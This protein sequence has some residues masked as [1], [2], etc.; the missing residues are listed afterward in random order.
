[1][2][3]FVFL[4]L[5]ERCQRLVAV[6]GSALSHRY[7]LRGFAATRAP[8]WLASSDTL[9]STTRRILGFAALLQSAVRR[10][11]TSHSGLQPP[12]N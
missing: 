1:M 2:G 10:V 7:D 9:V 4:R 3:S 6:A 8:S 11:R 12:T 5:D